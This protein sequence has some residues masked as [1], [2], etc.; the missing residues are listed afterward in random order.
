M[1]AAEDELRPDGYPA[2]WPQPEPPLETAV[3]QLTQDVADLYEAGGFRVDSSTWTR[4]GRPASA[5]VGTASASG[6]ETDGLCR[7]VSA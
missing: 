3:G 7:C 2:N 4:T 6:S 1:A 5:C